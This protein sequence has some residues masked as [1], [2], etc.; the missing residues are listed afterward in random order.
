M[1]PVRRGR[2]VQAKMCIFIKFRALW[3]RSV[4]VKSVQEQA[5]PQC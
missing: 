1:V 5:R 3:G 2:V 4:P